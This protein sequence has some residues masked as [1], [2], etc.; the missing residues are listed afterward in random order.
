MVL[1]NLI[2]NNGPQLNTFGLQILKLMLIS[3]LRL[4]MFENLESICRNYFSMNDADNY[5][6]VFGCGKE[7]KKKQDTGWTN[8]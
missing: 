8:Q 3:L 1:Q 4:K 2:L 7:L 6:K 5:V